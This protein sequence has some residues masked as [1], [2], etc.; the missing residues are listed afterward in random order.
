MDHPNR[1][2]G[3]V[4]L[5]GRR[6][7]LVSGRG[8]S[9]TAVA[10]AV[11]AL[12]A[13][14]G[15]AG[16][17]VAPVSAQELLPAT[18]Q[19]LHN[20]PVLENPRAVA[21]QILAEARFHDPPLPRPLKRPLQW[22]SDRLRPVGRGLSD[23][24]VVLARLLP[25]GSVTGWVVLGGVVFGLA[26]VAAGRLARRRVGAI[27]ARRVAAAAPGER[28]ARLLEREADEAEGAGDFGRAVRVRFRAGLLRL[29]A[30]RVL[31]FDPSLTTG[32][33]AIRLRSA[34]FD[35]MALR[36][37]EITYGRR[38]PQADDARVAR[39]GWERIL[40]EAPPR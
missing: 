17:R 8:V 32:A 12:L 29:D 10:V 36:Y 31:R 11:A 30:V 4:R 38:E 5:S 1:R 19:H 9:S 16:A 18:G 22:L 25:G 23:A 40:K 27:E 33:V 35:A 2:A 39:E 13:M 7:W 14:A 26:V 15:T 3:R 21:R 20:A 37:D 6:R 28:D 34:T 24:F